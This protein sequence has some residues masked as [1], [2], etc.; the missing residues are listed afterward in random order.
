MSCEDKSRFLQGVEELR[1]LVDRKPPVVDLDILRTIDQPDL[2]D[3]L[4]PEMLSSMWDR[5][6]SA[7]PR[8]EQFLSAWIKESLKR[9]DYVAAQKVIHGLEGLVRV[10]GLF[11]LRLRR[12]PW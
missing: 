2:Y 1:N 6:Q 4:D 8:N 3:Y 10:E 9:R 5:A 7:Q 11:L 12:G